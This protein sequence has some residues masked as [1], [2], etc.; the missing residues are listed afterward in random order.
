MDVHGRLHQLYV[1]VGQLQRSK[2]CNLSESTLAN[3]FLHNAN[4]VPSIATLEAICKG[5]E[6]T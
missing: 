6:I 5:F 1:C 3:I 4:T 2:K